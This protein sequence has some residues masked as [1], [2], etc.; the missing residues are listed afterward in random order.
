[1]EDVDIWNFEEDE[2]PYDIAHRCFY[3]AK[4]VIQF[5][6]TEKYEKVFHSLFDQLVRSASSIGANVVEGKSGSSKKDWA[7]FM[8]IALKSANETKYWI[9]LIRDTMQ[10]NSKKIGELLIEVDAISKIL[11]SI[12]L[13]S[14]N[15]G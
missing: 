12:L 14:R 1:M 5:V 13:K 8:T 11:A 3:F 15:T 6:A 10:I 2:K 4:D 9:C 7:K